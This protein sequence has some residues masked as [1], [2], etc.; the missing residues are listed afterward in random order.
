MAKLLLVG[1]QHFHQYSAFASIDPETGLN[2]RLLDQLDLL[3][4]IAKIR[5]KHQCDATVWLGDFWHS[6]TKLDA[7]VV[8]LVT[9]KV[10]ERWTGRESYFLV[11]NHDCLGD[12][13]DQNSLAMLSP[14]GRI[15]SEPSRLQLPGRV[16]CHAYPF[17]RNPELLKRQ[18]EDMHR[19]G[20]PDLLIAHC[21]LDEGAVGAYNISIKASVSIKDLPGAR[22]SALGHYHKPQEFIGLGGPVVYVG[23][24]Q[25]VDMGER[26]EQKSV[27]ILDTKT[28]EFTRI[29][30]SGP[31][32]HLYPDLPSA[33]R[34][35][36]KEQ[37]FIRIQCRKAEAEEA[38]NEF[39]KAQIEV[40]KD[41]TKER[42][43]IDTTAGTSDKS[44]L[45]SYLNERNPEL[46]RER[47]LRLGLSLLE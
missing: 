19:F 46:D 39:P 42:R 36:H 16:K 28:W 17:Q 33:R 9:E 4:E 1:D 10:Y 23:S 37:D 32:F 6:R 35:R 45:E 21:G 47:L 44:L 11:G 8:S 15:I 41:L 13:P 20:K 26:D 2:S 25:Q 34:G 3:D 40:V 14:L 43:V 12:T 24:I 18:F 22:F 27:I 38:K 30:L 29:P 31:E 7:Q 5:D